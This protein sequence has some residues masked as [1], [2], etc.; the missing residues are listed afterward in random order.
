MLEICPYLQDA[1]RMRETFLVGNTEDEGNSTAAG[2]SSGTKD[3]EIQQ[4]RRAELIACLIFISIIA[5]MVLYICFG[6]QA[7][8]MDGN[9]KETNS[10]STPNG[11]QQRL[12]TTPTPQLLYKGSQF[13]CRQQV[14]KINL[15]AL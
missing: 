2:A 13:I 7:E 9:C 8:K 10:V 4:R 14:L 6:L 5:G 15:N 3:N 1:Q 11:L 12:A